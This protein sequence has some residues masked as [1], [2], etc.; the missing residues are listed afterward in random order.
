MRSEISNDH[1]IWSACLA[2]DAD[3]VKSLISA[4]LPLDAVG[5]ISAAIQG[6]SPDVIEVFLDNAYQPNA[7]FN[8]LGET[9]LMRAIEKKKW[10]ITQLLL[11]RGANVNACASGGGTPLHAAAG[12]WPE[13]IPILLQAGAQVSARLDEGRTPMMCAAFG[14]QTKSLELLQNAGASLEEKDNRHT[15][16]LILAAK[17]GKLEALQ[18]LLDHGADINAKDDRG[19]TALDWAKANGHAKCV[20]V[21]QRHLDGV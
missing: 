13:A 14:N 8:D 5:L 20:E 6:G 16:A 10:E 15:T 1:P 9:P 12:S 3:K 2:G 4:D 19:K 18:W 11:Q 17:G 21:L 7:I